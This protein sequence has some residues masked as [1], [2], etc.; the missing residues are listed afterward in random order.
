LPQLVGKAIFHGSPLASGYEVEWDFL[1]PDVARV[2]FGAQ[3]GLISWT[4]VAGLALVGLVLTTRRDRRLGLGLL[5]VFLGML[6]MVAA[7]A[8]PEQSSY[9]NRFFV[10]FVPGFVVGAAV[11]ADAVWDR[12]KVIA[13]A[14]TGVL[15]VWNAL[16]AFQWAWGLVPKRAPVDWGQMVR[17]QFTTAPR[18]LVRAVGLFFTDRAAL[19]QHVQEADLRGLRKGRDLPSG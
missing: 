12:R 2:L 1:R 3:H 10:L 17:N 4:P 16:F 7:Y 8:T 15:V 11:V 5:A 14:V 13:V 19:I 18:E 9:G 6:Y